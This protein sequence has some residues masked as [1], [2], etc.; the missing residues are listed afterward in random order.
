M[1]ARLYIRPVLQ[2]GSCP[3]A[4]PVFA[5][6]HKLK[7]GWA[8]IDGQPQRFRKYSYYLRYVREG[9]RV[10][11]G[12]GADPQ[13]ALA[14]RAR[15]T[16]MLMARMSPT[17]SEPAPAALPPELRQV[18]PAPP[19]RR[20]FGEARDKYIAEMHDHKAHKTHLAYKLTLARF[21]RATGC[22]YLDQMTRDAVLAYVKWEADQ[23][24][25]PRTC[26]TRVTYLRSFMLWCG[27]SFPLVGKDFPKYTEKKV[28]AYRPDAVDAMLAVAD[29]D[30]SDLLYFFLCTGTREKEAQFA[31][32]TDVDLTEKTYTVTEHRDLGY[33]PKDHE[34]GTVP[35][36]DVLVGRLRARRTRY[37]RTRLIFDYE[38]N[39]NGH[40]LRIIKQLGFRAGINCGQCVNRQGL[41]CADHPVC[42]DVILHKLR[43]T[44]ASQLS[45]NGVPPRTIMRYLRHSDLETTLKYLAD[46]DDDQLRERVNNTFNRFGGGC[47]G[48]RQKE[49]PESNA[50]SYI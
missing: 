8:I 10:W 14:A 13:V 34:E 50:P 43:K 24:N 22:Q 12:V 20:P 6:N 27:L 36:P 35:I 40:L 15:V 7:N 42:K 2:D 30:E 23:G 39:P 3:F 45:R 38:G 26:H 37:P 49:C 9:K 32:W 18:K 44:F 21:E 1:K 5:A 29:E 31:C 11:E 25:A 4:D 33:V 16:G 46:E 48:H 19:A 28:K 41:S 47:G 17:A